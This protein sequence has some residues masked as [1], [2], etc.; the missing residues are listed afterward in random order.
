MCILF[1]YI[2]KIKKPGEFRLILI[3]NR[4]EFFHRPCNI[5]NFVNENNLYGKRLWIDY[6][7]RRFFFL[8]RILFYGLAT[9]LTPGK[10]GGTW[11]GVSKLGR[12]GV[13]LNLS[14]KNY[15]NDP[16]KLGRGIDFIV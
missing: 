11:L 6:E 1:S 2:S 13:L 16:N 5:A 15:P 8:E 9:D 10:E 14:S 12:I 3:N 4:D 7:F